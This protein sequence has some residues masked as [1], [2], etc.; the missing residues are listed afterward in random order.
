MFRKI[1]LLVSFAAILSACQNRTNNQSVFVPPYIPL[2]SP[3]QISELIPTN[4]PAVPIIPEATPFPAIPPCGNEITL[5]PYELK[6]CTI[7]HPARDGQLEATMEI[8]DFTAV[9]SLRRYYANKEDVWL[10]FLDVQDLPAT[11]DKSVE[12]NHES[13]GQFVKVTIAKEKDTQNNETD[14][15]KVHIEQ[16][17]NYFPVVDENCVGTEAMSVLETLHVIKQIKEPSHSLSIQIKGDQMVL[18]RWKGNN[19]LKDPVTL[20]TQASPI[21]GKSKTILTDQTTG[22][23]IVVS[24]CGGGIYDVHV[25]K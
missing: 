14:N 2:T 8:W 23:G 16:S 11:T 17:Q 13:N 7:T 24:N 18:Q 15:Y 20:D 6:I 10:S 19:I 25:S 22:N 21:L 1:L 4:V 12:L 3:T 9:L 5:S